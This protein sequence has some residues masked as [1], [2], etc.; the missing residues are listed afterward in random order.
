MKINKPLWLWPHVLLLFF[1]HSVVSDSLPPHGLQHARLPCPSPSPGAFPVMSIELVMPSN[2][3]I[4]CLPLSSC[5]QSSPASGSFLMSQLF[6]SSGQSIR[7]SDFSLS[8]SS[9]YSWLI[10]FRI[11]WFDLLVVQQNLKSLFQHHYLK[12]QFFCA[13]LSLW[14]NSHTHTW[15]LEK[16]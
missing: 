3:L 5:F 1:S 4:L 13:Q 7:A 6:A 9:E 14:S 2:N 16:S 8:H 11:N 10:S 15:L 12:H